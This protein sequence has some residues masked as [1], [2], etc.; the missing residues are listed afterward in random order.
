MTTVSIHSMTLAALLTLAGCATPTERVILLPDAGGRATAV[1]VESS[2][3]QVVV[4]TA[5]SEVRVDRDGSFEDRS[6]VAAQVESEFAAVLESRPPKPLKF[7][8]YFRFDSDELT[9]ESERSVDAM[10]SAI[11]ARPAPEVLIV[12]HTDTRGEAAYNDTLSLRRAEVVR[13]R[14]QSRLEAAG[15]SPA[16]ISVAGRGE[17]EPLVPGEDDRDEPRNRRVEMAVR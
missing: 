16:R 4:D 12:G 13:D 17:R 2:S 9:T 5:W 6:A 8:L 11:A 3:G 1:V 14:L 10:L 15:I 7:V